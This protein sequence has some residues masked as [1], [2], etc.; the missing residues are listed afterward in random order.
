MSYRGSGG[1]SGPGGGGYPGSRK[2]SDASSSSSSGGQRGFS[3]NAVPP[4]SSLMGRSNPFHKHTPGGAKQ[5]AAAGLSKHGYSTMDAIS[6][7]AN[8][9]QYAIGKRKSKTEDEYEMFS[10]FLS[11]YKFL[12]QPLK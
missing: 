9:S 6:Q 1:R 8:S 11:Y 3:M 4:P 2:S 7:F 12:K 5:A 10:L